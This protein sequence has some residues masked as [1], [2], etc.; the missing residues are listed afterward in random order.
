MGFRCH[1]ISEACDKGCLHPL[2]RNLFLPLIQRTLTHWFLIEKT[3]Q[4]AVVS[5]YPSLAI[6][7]DSRTAS[8]AAAVVISRSDTGSPIDDWT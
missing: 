2:L 6:K 4:R 8:A 3:H 5:L 7:R 1:A